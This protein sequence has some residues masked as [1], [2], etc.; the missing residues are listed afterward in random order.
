MESSEY[1]WTT[2]TYEMLV[3]EPTQCSM[4]VVGFQFEQFE[5]S[6]GIDLTA[7]SAEYRCTS[8]DPKFVIAMFAF[9]LTNLIFDHCGEATSLGQKMDVFEHKSLGLF[10]GFTPVSPFGLVC[11]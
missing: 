5:Q 10:E 9:P 6:V 3:N 4:A 8:N 1:A 7:K 2:F 11:S